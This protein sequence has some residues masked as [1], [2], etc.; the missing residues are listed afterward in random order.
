MHCS[1]LWEISAI[2]KLET[3]RFPWQLHDNVMP[4]ITVQG[5][6]DKVKSPTSDFKRADSE[7]Y[8]SE[9]SKRHHRQPVLL[10]IRFLRCVE[11][12]NEAETGQTLGPRRIASDIG[13]VNPA[14]PLLHLPG[15]NS[16]H[17][18]HFA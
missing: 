13:M 5:D 7:P 11:N 15:M 9:T 17:M 1:I 10:Q 8:R 3:L 6:N 14:R 2:E 12:T 4:I 16:H 18:I